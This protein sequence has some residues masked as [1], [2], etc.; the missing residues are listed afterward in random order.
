M[1]DIQS[2]EQLLKIA[3][4]RLYPSLTSPSYLVQRRRRLILSEWIARIPAGLL[5]V[6]DVGGRYQPYRSLLEGRISRY[7]ALDVLRTKLV[8]V[9]GSGEELPFQSES[10]DVVLATAVFDYF[11]EPRRAAREI[12]RVLKPGGI[13]MVSAPAV[14]PRSNDGEL[15]RYLPGG[16]RFVLGSFEKV[17]IVAEVTSVGGLFRIVAASLDIMARYQ[18]LRRLLRYTAIPLLNLAGLAL[19]RES[20]SRNEQVAGSYCARAQK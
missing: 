3:R 2:R 12:H 8:D 15:W 17:E 10:F 7:V 14:C 18:W 4:E 19:D 16:L 20:I 5:T 13:L 1:D 9:V 6:L 11:P